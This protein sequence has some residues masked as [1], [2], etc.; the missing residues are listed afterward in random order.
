MSDE[1]IAVLAI[2]FGQ[3]WIFIAMNRTDGIIRDE[4]DDTADS[5]MDAFCNKK[6]FS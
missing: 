5:L 3:P 4:D 1:D 6:A 2:P